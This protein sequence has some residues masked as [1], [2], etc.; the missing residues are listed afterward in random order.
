MRPKM[1]PPLRGLLP[2]EASNPPEH[3][4]RFL[5]MTSARSSPED[6]RANLLRS[7]MQDVL[8]MADGN[9]EH[10]AFLMADGAPIV[11]MKREQLARLLQDEHPEAAR[12]IMAGPPGLVVACAA[13]GGVSVQS[14]NLEDHRRFPL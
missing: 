3:G 5:L 2:I 6:V 1:T 9:P 7:G 4:R 13:V 14:L 12:Q 10:D 11:G 8:Q